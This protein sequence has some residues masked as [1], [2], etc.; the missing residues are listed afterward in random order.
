M[1]VY[2]DEENE[3]EDVWVSLLLLRTEANRE[4][5]QRRLWWVE[6]ESN[7]L[8]LCT[9]MYVCMCMWLCMCATTNESIKFH[10]LVCV[11]VFEMCRRSISSTT[12]ND[13]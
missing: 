9:R 4:E 13:R 12:E 10:L 8:V 5:K 3:D 6:E 7:D 2:R 11:R 1:L